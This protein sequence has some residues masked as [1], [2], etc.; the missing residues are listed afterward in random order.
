MKINTK[1]IEL[2]AAKRGMTVTELA[3]AMEMTNQNFNTIHRRGSCKAITVVRIARALHCEPEEIIQE[4][5]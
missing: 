1:K 5:G 3:Q 4:G 2:L